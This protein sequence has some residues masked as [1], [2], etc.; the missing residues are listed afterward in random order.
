[1]KTLV[2][3]LFAANHQLEQQHI[4]NNN[5]NFLI[6]VITFVKVIVQQNH[7]ILRLAINK[8]NKISTSK[9]KYV[10]CQIIIG[11]LTLMLKSQML[12]KVEDA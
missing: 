2:K 7:Q 11:H 5:K 10:T 12:L 4:N 8:I 3:V 1:M 9:L 6:K